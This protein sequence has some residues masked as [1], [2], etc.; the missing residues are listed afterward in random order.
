M[1]RSKRVEA[2]IALSSRWGGD[3]TDFWAML[4]F[5]AMYTGS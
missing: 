2:V 5:Q 1:Q 4:A 3:S